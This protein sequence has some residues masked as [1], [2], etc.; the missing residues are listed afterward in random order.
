MNPQASGRD[1]PI[2]RVAV[3]VMIGLL[4]WGGICAAAAGGASSIAASFVTTESASHSRIVDFAAAAKET[5]AG[6]RKAHSKCQLLAGT[7]RRTCNSE[8]RKEEQRRFAARMNPETT[9]PQ[10][11]Q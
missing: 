6:Y 11:I 1:N 8:A 9:H 10:E 5:A 4:L 2:Y 3:G 7:A